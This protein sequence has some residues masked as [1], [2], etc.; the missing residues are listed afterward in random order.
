MDFRYKHKTCGVHLDIGTKP[1]IWF[2][3][4]YSNIA[5]YQHFYYLISQGIMMD[6]VE[7]SQEYLGGWNQ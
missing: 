4:L 6:L 3:F 5:R 1:G 2:H 7:N